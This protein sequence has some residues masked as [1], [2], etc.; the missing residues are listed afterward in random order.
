MF[1]SDFQFEAS[2]GTPNDGGVVEYSTNGGTTW[3]DAAPLMDGGQLYN[4]TLPA[5]NPLGARQAFT[6][7]SGAYVPTTLDL[8]GLTGQSFKLRF[9]TGTDA[10]GSD[11]GWFVDDVGIFRCIAGVPTDWD[12][13]LYPDIFW[14]NITTGANRVWTMSN[15]SR[16]GTLNLPAF[17]NTTSRVGAVADFDKNGTPDFVATDTATGQAIMVLMK[18]NLKVMKVKA[19]AALP[20]GWRIAAAGDFDGDGFTDIVARNP[21]LGVTVIA[22]WN[23]ARITAV[24]RI[25]RSAMGASL[26]IDAAGDMDQD[27]DPDLVWR[28][29]TT[30][31]NYVQFLNN[32]TTTSVKQIARVAT[33]LAVIEQISDFDLNGTMD[34]LWRHYGTGRNQIWYMNGTTRTGKANIP[35][36]TNP[37]WN[38]EN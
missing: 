5:G 28:D 25:D 37:D 15:A 9:R 11:F 14:N 4:G 2:M 21:V 17:P 7:S 27:G 36:E 12:N 22:Y 33:P 24:R 34:I 31:R 35:N 10:A 13:D 8:S 32:R 3:M 6:A 23:G 16:T 20:A 30:G 38:I 19:L 29:Y 26:R 18:S 1:W